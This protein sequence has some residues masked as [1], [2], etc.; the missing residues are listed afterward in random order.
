MTATSVWKIPLQ[1]GQAIKVLE[2]LSSYLNL[3]IVPSGLYFVPIQN[4]AHARVLAYPGSS[5][6]FLDFGSGRIRSVANLKELSTCPEA[7]AA[8]LFLQMVAGFCIRRSIKPAANSCWWKTLSRP[9][10]VTKRRCGPNTPWA[11]WLNCSCCRSSDVA[12]DA[13]PLLEVNPSF[14]ITSRARI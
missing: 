6:Q 1:G 12:R 3:A 10:A 11:I 13:Q 14:T 7:P 2:G 9:H 4:A 8:W 5:I